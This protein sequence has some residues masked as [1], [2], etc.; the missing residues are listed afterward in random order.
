MTPGGVK[1]SDCCNTFRDCLD[2]RPPA[3]GGS[4]SAGSPVPGRSEQRRFGLRVETGLVP[5][6][7]GATS[8]GENLRGT[9]EQPSVSRGQRLTLDPL[10]M[11][12][13]DSEIKFQPSGRE[14]PARSIREVAQSAGIGS[15]RRRIRIA[16][17]RFFNDANRFSRSP[18]R[19][20]YAI[21]ARNTVPQS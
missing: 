7:H 2:R 16:P 13:I 5:A 19:L 3:I 6:G 12:A 10:Q 17:S 18:I 1:F 20:R 15:L 11:E 4:P 14:N 21:L 9:F 8:V